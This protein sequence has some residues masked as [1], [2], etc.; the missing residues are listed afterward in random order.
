VSFG[1]L[2]FRD[3]EYVVA[4]ADARSFT[5]A[6]ER[7]GVAQ[8]SLS[9]Q[10]RKVERQLGAA[11]FE[12]TG[13]EIKTTVAGDAI[14][15]QARTVLG[16]GRRLFELS[17]G[18]GDPLAGTLTLGA[19]ATLGPYLIPHILGPLRR[20]HPGLNLIL[21][22]GLTADLTAAMSSG[23]VDAV[24]MSLPA[25]DER[26]MAEP[27][28]FEPF[29]GIFPA[30]SAL[31]DRDHIALA[32]LDTEALILM[33]EGHCVRDQALS[34]C[35]RADRRQ[36][37]VASIETLR[38]L[39]AAGAG[40]SLLPAL[41]ARQDPLLDGQLRYRP[42]DERAG[43]LIGLCWRASDPRGAHF[44]DLARFIAA[45]PVPGTVRAAEFN[46]SALPD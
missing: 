32:D 40:H 43:R 21:R 2:T 19:I 22:E 23:E 18:L 38:H 29:L 13:R 10:V 27:I 26:L 35:T 30:A 7:C 20:A 12:R 39:V 44:A 36:R 37:H 28:L 25:H 8:P 45:I 1:G 34:L 42:L 5:A 4:V 16:E 31:A 41:A 33:D 11:I 9:A 24:L 6:A 3:L 15:A 46:A 14:L 17:K